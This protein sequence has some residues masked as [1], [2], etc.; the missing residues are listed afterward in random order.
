MLMKLDNETKNKIIKTIQNTNINND[1]I[2][3]IQQ[4]KHCELTNKILGMIFE[5]LFVNNVGFS[6]DIKIKQLIN[7]HYAFKTNNGSTWARNNIS[8]LGHK[9]YIIKTYNQGKIYSIKCDGL[10]KNKKYNNINKDIIKEIKKQNCVILD[11]N[12]NIECDHKDGMKNDYRVA[13]M[14]TQSINDFQPMCKIVNIAKRTHCKR[15]TTSGKRYDATQ[16][17]YSVPYIYGNENSKTCIGCYWFD[18][19]EF[20]KII[21]ARYKKDK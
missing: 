8:Y 11:I 19:K 21:S 7:I 4:Y 16:L 20:N 1:L 10:L 9:Y 17:G 3:F 12:S 15:C 18:P 2:L 14:K 5:K 13:N 6:S